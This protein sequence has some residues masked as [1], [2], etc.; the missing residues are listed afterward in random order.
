[1]DKKKIKAVAEAYERIQALDSDLKDIHEAADKA[2]DKKGSAW[3]SIDFEDDIIK[4]MQESTWVTTTTTGIY[5]NSAPSE[6]TGFSLQVPD[7]VVL[8]VLGVILRHKQQL[9]DHES[10]NI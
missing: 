1:M 4:E 2:L 8:E 7:T 6:D 9:I 10:N 5:A 3:I